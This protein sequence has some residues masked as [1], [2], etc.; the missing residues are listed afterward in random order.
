MDHQYQSNNIPQNPKIVNNSIYNSMNNSISQ[1]K[2][3][4]SRIMNT[5]PMNQ[6]RS[7]LNNQSKIRTSMDQSYMDD[8]ENMSQT[9]TIRESIKKNQSRDY[10]NSQFLQN[11]Q[12]AQSYSYDFSTS[13]QMNNKNK[14]GQK[15]NYNES[16]N[17]IY[18][19]DFESEARTSSHQN[20]PISTQYN[21]SYD[22]FSY[23]NSIQ[24]SGFC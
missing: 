7:I 21:M 5:P 2:P 24:K 19:D 15:Y 23:S 3:M 10:S 16:N 6:N 14:K 8:F 20:K 22:N 12:L 11:T 18:E 1:K 17:Q 4:T 9:N 13:Q